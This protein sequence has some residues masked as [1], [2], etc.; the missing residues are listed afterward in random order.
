M[1]KS[2]CVCACVHIFAMYVVLVSTRDR[3]KGEGSDWLKAGNKRPEGEL[4]S[5]AS[6][7]IR[8]DR[9]V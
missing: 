8:W 6:D 5:L 3:G 9:N 4:T 1:L 2:E 7:C